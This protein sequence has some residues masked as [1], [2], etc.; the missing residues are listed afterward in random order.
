MY[1]WTRPPCVCMV[2]HISRREEAS[3]KSK[4]S[5]ARGGK[6]EYFGSFGARRQE[7]RKRVIVWSLGWRLHSSWGAM[8]QSD[9]RENLQPLCSFMHLQQRDVCASEEPGGKKVGES[10]DSWWV[11][12]GEVKAGT[13][14]S[15][16]D[17]NEAEIPA[18][19]RWSLCQN[20]HHP[21]RRC[22]DLA[23]RFP[24]M[25]LKSE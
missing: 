20:H 12:E 15:W 3:E 6:N 19:T 21:L 17:G 25:Q 13:G 4:Q 11:K 14:K 2:G 23:K 18:Q 5:S 7:Q 9:H 16:W 8:G 22:H 1:E 24:S 10:G